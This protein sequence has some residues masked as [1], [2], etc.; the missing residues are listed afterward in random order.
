MRK[1]V[2]M[3]ATLMLAIGMLALVLLT[4]MGTSQAAT[5]ASMARIR[6]LHASPDAP[7]VDVLAN[8]TDI[9]TNAAYSALTPYIAVPSGTYTITLE[10]AM[11]GSAVY[12]QIL[13]VMGDTDY[14]VA[15]AG[16]F[17]TADTFDF[18]LMPFADDNQTVPGVGKSRA[19]FIHLSPGAPEVDIVV[20]GGPTLFTGVAYGESGGYVEVPAA[21]YVLDIQ[22]SG[23]GLTA[24]TAT[25]PVIPNSIYTFFAIGLP[26]GTG[27]LALQAL[28]SLDMQYARVRAFH[29][30]FD[31]PA[32]DVQVNGAP[33]F[34]GVMFQDLSD[35]A[36]LP[37][38]T[39]TVGIAPTGVMTPVITDT[40]M[41]AGGMDYTVAAAGTLT[42]TDP[43]TAGLV[44]FVDNNLAPA[45]G[46]AHLRFIHLVPGAPGVDVGLPGGPVLITNTV[47]QAASAYLPVAAGTYD[48]EATVTA[49]TTVVATMDNARLLEG[50]IYDAIAVPSETGIGIDVVLAPV[51][52]IW[53]PIIARNG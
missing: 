4:Q 46:N 18:M 31:A 27:P 49:S 1:Y 20:P 5:A 28:P 30:I 17:T 22:L 34:V 42:S 19:R 38:G 15:A 50:V 21:T 12:T 6:V 10:P 45:A 23:S 25:V 32:V 13:T 35:Y 2:T 24:L 48:L 51:H 8:G 39:Y 47:Y 37:P 11:G 9:F 7:P 26:A 52:T 53:M 44:P 3:T 14:T 16:T 43:Y 41:L 40:F 33:A 29:G 36:A